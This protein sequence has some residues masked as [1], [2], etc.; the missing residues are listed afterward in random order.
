MDVERTSDVSLKKF[1]DEGKRT[2]SASQKK[3]VD[4]KADAFSATLGS[5]KSAK[6]K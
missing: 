2:L 3:E 5:N 1:T 4:E 6:E